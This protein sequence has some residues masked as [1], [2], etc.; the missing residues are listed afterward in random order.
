MA[1]HAETMLAAIKTVL[2]GRITSDVESYTI[3]GRQITKIPIPELIK[4]YNHYQ[5]MVN[6][7]KAAEDIANGLGNPNTI[8]VRF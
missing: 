1:T 7:E 6:S 3:G 4:I 2:E 5:S 8:K